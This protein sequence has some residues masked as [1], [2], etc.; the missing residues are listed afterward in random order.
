MLEVM[1]LLPEK[2][3]CVYKRVNLGRIVVKVFLCPLCTLARPGALLQIF[4]E[5]KRSNG[6]HPN[7]SVATLAC[8]VYC[9]D[10]I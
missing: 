7:S 3:V 9:S 4:R 1:A 10:G 5:K 8:T 2:S 6:H